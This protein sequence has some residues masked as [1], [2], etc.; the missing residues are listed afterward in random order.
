VL[1][2]QNISYSR[3]CYIRFKSEELAKSA[4]KELNKKKVNG[5]KLIVTEMKKYKMS[6]K[7]TPQLYK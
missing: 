2:K 4:L 3:W 6:N 5:G 7:R 1:A